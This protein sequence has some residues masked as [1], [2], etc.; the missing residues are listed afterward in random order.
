MKVMCIKTGEWNHSKKTNHPKFGDIVTAVKELDFPE[1]GVSAYILEEYP[2]PGGYNKTCFIPLS[3][4][5]ETTLVK[6]TIEQ[7]A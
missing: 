1:L 3:D 2:H 4:I 5:D 7:T 6:E